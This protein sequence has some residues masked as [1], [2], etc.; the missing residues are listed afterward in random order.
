MC[1][2]MKDDN[3]VLIFDKDISLKEI[4][5]EYIKYTSIFNCKSINENDEILDR[6]INELD[7]YIKEKEMS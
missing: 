6:L 4:I 3:L 1:F 5:M 7:S 2:A